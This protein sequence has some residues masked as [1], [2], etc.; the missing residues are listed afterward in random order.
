MPYVVM[1]LMI[2]GAFVSSH[3]AARKGRSAVHWWFI[4]LVPVFGIMLALLMDTG[5]P[6]GVT[7][8][9]R[10]GRRRKGAPPRK[11]P[12]RCCGSYIPECWG[13][14]FFRRNLFDPDPHEG[15]RGYCEH[16]RHELT[17]PPDEDGGTIIVD[18]E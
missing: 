16:F 9:E 2:V 14:P 1:T 18:D 17:E 11:R 8:K 12:K 13:C 5:A 4:G 6:A 3:I 10:G 7:R 15:K